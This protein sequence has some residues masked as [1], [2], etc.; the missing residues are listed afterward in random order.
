MTMIFD[1]KW[2]NERQF[3]VWRTPRNWIY[4]YVT[5]R[6]PCHSLVAPRCI[7]GWALVLGWFIRKSAALQCSEYLLVC[8][9]SFL[10]WPTL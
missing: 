8:P 4:A 9:L 2:L 3:S 5:E 1:T 7:C 6:R 10:G